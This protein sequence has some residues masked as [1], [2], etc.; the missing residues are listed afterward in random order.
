MLQSMPLVT[1][2]FAAAFAL[3]LPIGR[4][5]LI[6]LT[7]VVG[8]GAELLTTQKAYA[9]TAEYWIGSAEE[10]YH[11]DD[12]QGAIADYTKAIEINPLSEVAYAYRGEMKQL[13]GKYSEALI[14]LNKAIELDPGY[15]FAYFI[16]AIIKSDLKDYQGAFADFDKAIEIDPLNESNY[17]MRA[18]IKE[19]MGDLQGACSDWRKA[20]DLGDS[21]AIEWVRNQC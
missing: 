14:D 9:K 10:K 17:G 18:L 3:F 7:P 2:A 12:Y 16:R 15:G 5:L 8:I 1:T 19:N 21:Y 4:P 13:L 6:G 20:A 11:N